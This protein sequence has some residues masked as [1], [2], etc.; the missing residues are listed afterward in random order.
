MVVAIT[1]LL[2]AH[3]T[4]RPSILLAQCPDGSPPPCRAPSVGPTRIAID[5]NAVAIL[6][7][8]VS[9]PSAQ[10]AWLREGMAD[11]MGIAL[12]DIAGWRVIPPEVVHRHPRVAGDDPA[13][14][15]SVA[16]ALGA[17]GVITGRVVAVGSELRVHVEWHESMNGARLASTNVRGEA[18]QPARL[19]DSLAT[20]LVRQRLSRTATPRRQPLEQYTTASLSALR[21]YLVAEQL[22]RRARWNEAADSLMVAI[23]RDSTFA[24]AYYRLYRA[25]VWASPPPTTPLPA[26]AIVAA[27]LRYQLRLP[28]RQRQIL[29]LLQAIFDGR[30]MDA[31]RIADQIALLY[32]DDPDVALE[33][34]DLYWHEGLA[35]GERPTRVLHLM[36]RA[37]QLDP[38]VPEPY[39]HVAQLRWIVGDTVGAWATVQRARHQ[40]PNEPT[41]HG[42]ELA[43]RVILH[44][45][46][47][48]TVVRDL[49]PEERG[50]FLTRMAREVHWTMEQD[51]VRVLALA[52]SIAAL[53]QDPEISR[54]RRVRTLLERHVYRLARGRRTSS[55]EMLQHA[56]ALDPSNPRTLGQTVVHALVTGAH[57]AEAREAAQRLAAF[58]GDATSPAWASGL[59]GLW[60]TSAGP[61]E[62]LEVAL[63]RITPRAD[64]PAPYAEALRTGLRGLARLA[65]HDSAPARELLSATYATRKDHGLFGPWVF[66]PH[67][68][69]SLELARLAF[70]ASDLPDAER[71]LLDLFGGFFVRGPY[72]GEAFELRAQIAEQ[73]GDSAA[74]IRAYRTFIEMWS[75]ADAELQPRVA[76]ARAAL[77]RLER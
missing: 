53:G 9:G 29:L 8:H 77:A 12:D 43:M 27:G 28:G 45:E 65:A 3:P 16:Q 15:R 70:A 74:A 22:A 40:W 52:D 38:D 7:F 62:S 69:F 34:G 76:V 31:L 56:V 2:S 5:S 61:A 10:T 55:W 4:I 71:H 64:R 21:A 32:P 50:G 54:D 6:P 39:L 42:L 49:P 60:V 24:L 17:G 36:E 73:R 41:L 68:R 11:L 57:G 66:P 14:A 59:V 20:Q 67:G 13:A 48:A 35:L 51:P 58:A 1:T 72:L 26:E 37:L 30:R 75:D 18:S 25:I 63:A 44:N 19:A 47:P 46:D 23:Q 33:H